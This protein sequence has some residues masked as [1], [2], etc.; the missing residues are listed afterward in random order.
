M[1]NMSR[2]F[3]L[4]C[5]SH[6]VL[7]LIKT[8][9]S[10]AKKKNNY[11]IIDFLAQTSQLSKLPQKYSIMQA[12]KSEKS[13]SKDPNTFFPFIH[14]Q[15]RLNLGWNLGFSLISARCDDY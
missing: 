1:V 13:T 4:I 15:C 6:N 14:N 11:K 2:I 10:N 3:E 9:T 12:V 5:I 7:R 8:S